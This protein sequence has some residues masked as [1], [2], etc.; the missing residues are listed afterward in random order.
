MK[1]EH[2]VQALK[3]MPENSTATELIVRGHYAAGGKKSPL[4]INLKMGDTPDGGMK[5]E[6]V[7]QTMKSMPETT[8]ITE[9]NIKGH[10]M[11]VSTKVPLS[12]NLNTGDDSDPGKEDSV[13]LKS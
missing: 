3:S 4:E 2:A 5:F 13:L 9:V 12:M 11:V 7:I 6:H 8:T 1:I 10:Y